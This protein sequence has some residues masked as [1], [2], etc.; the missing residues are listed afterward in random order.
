MMNDDSNTTKSGVRRKHGG[1]VHR[2]AVGIH[3][4][5]AP[6]RWHGSCS[7]FGVEPRRCQ[8]F[9]L[10]AYPVLATVLLI[11]HPSA[12]SLS[13]DDGWVNLLAKAGPDLKGWTRGPIPPTG[14]LDAKSQWSLDPATGNLVCDGTRGHEWLRW[15]TE[16]SDFEFHVEFRYTD[17]E[18]KRGYN[19]GIYVRNSADAA[20][21]H[22]AQIGDRSGG[23]LFGETKS[24]DKLKSF[25]LPNQAKP[26]PVKRAGEWNTVDLRCRGKG[27]TL[28]V[29]GQQTCVW[30]D[31]E[32]PSG[33]VGVEAEGY[34]IEFRN[35]KVKRLESKS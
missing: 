3:A 29:N 30:H 5:C 8:N 23:F 2:A 13:Q 7:S 26:N 14:K 12:L 32:V 9:R 19:S 31:C 10:K 4:F 34:R 25:N 24:G 18:G 27:V 16:L 35:V 11:L 6:R 22:Q 17:V 15:D 33:F 1:I 20:I 21:W 28:K